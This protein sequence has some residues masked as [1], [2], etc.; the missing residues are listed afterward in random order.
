[1]AAIITDFTWGKVSKYNISTYEIASA[2]DLL[3]FKGK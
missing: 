3:K 1:M 2:R